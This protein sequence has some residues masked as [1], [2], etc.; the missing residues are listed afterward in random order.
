MSLAVGVIGAGVMGAEHAR[1]LREQ[2]RGAHLAAVCDADPAR[3]V[4]A[5]AG[6]RAFADAHALITSNDVQA[7]VVASPDAT[8]AEYVLA[9]LA[10]GK[11]VL[12]EKPIAATAADA[13]RVVDAEVALSR[14]LVQVG[15]MRRFDAG[16]AEMRQARMEGS[17][18]T[19]TV[20]HN[21]HRNLAAPEWFTGAMA[22]TNAF[23][24]E[25]DIS[26]WL[27]DSEIVAAQIFPAGGVGTLV[28]VMRTDKGE[29]ISTEVSVNGGYGYHVHAQIVGTNGTIE[30]TVPTHTLTNQAGVHAFQFPPNWVP[31]FAQAYRDEMQAW[32]DAIARGSATGAS[33]WDGYVATA[34]A[35]NIAASL[36]GGLAVE[37]A[38]PARP[39]LYAEKV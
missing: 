17:I 14:R 5:A 12:C 35:E 16:Y 3:A 26:R 28:I 2:T 6:A 29:I 8:H 23:I 39:P 30:T 11:P 19:P 10:A 38:L 33:A 34:I 32:V 15:F 7:V 18:G 22:V 20:V 21:V 27:L 13:L 24:H 9:T 36:P 37:I 4:G 1:I 25:I 31:R